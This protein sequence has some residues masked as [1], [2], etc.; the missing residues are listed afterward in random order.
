MEKGA[1]KIIK[2]MG[3]VDFKNRAEII[4]PKKWLIATLNCTHYG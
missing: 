4:T 3:K 1:C 2:Q